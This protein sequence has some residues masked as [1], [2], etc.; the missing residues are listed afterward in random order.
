MIS[1]SKDG[2]IIATVANLS[3]WKTARGSSSR[4]GKAA[5]A[6]MI[7]HMRQHRIGAHLLDGPRGPAGIVKAGVIKIALDSGAAIVPMTVSA[8][9]AWYAGS[10]DR[11]MLPKPFSQVT[12]RFHAPMWLEPADSEEVFEAYRKKLEDYL[13]P[14][15]IVP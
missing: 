9:K 2:D 15:L 5:M 12:L 8:E 10:W 1:K 3:G 4:D 13:R 11:F 7:D 6:A 14:Y